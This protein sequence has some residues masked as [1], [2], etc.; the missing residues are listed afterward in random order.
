MKATLQARLSVEEQRSLA[1]LVDRLGW[2]PSRIVREG[3]RLVS[4]AHGP[5]G[6]R[7]AGLGRF[8]SGIPDLGSNK[9]HLKGFGR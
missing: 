5:A 2:S 1:R 6:Q 9:K 4:A 3:L 8:A 7:I